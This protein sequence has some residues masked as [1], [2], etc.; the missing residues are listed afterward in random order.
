M[1]HRNLLKDFKRPKSIIFERDEVNEFYGKF[2]ASPLERGFGVTIANSLRRTLLSVMQGY[3]ITAIRVEFT[4]GEGKQEM[5]TNEFTSI[6]GMLEETIDFIQNLKKVRLK[7]DNEAES[8]TIMI[9][10]KGEFELK[11][12]DL[13][14]DT[15]IKV[16]NPDLL[17]ATFNEEAEIFMEI[18]IDY[19]RGY[20]PSDR[21]KDFVDVIGTIPI[22][23]IFSPVKHVNFTIKNTRV[24]QRTDY[25]K[26]ILEV[27]TDGTLKPE[28]AVARAA[29]ILKEYY[30]CFINFDEEEEPIEEEKDE[31]QERL[32]QIYET[33]IEDLEFSVRTAT[34]LKV[35]GVRTIGELV[36]KT[37]EELEKIKH[38]GKKSVEEIVD[39]LKSLGLNL[40]AKDLNYIS[41]LK[42]MM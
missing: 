18:Q 17:L 24:G 21:S 40:G 38:I 41:K 1:G 8:K 28:D 36:Q 42:S 13:E 30:T 34:S 23:A 3:A 29:K 12:K 19:G 15:S 31:E 32:R 14:V 9:E 26:V 22:D 5:L 27:F 39:K 11:A 6:H 2:I 35:G 16:M 25:D 4:D 10:K 7:L 37:P 20:I 33:T